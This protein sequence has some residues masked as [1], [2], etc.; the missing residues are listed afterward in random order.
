LGDQVSDPE[1]AL[2][3]LPFVVSDYFRATG[4][5]GDGE[6]R[7]PIVL[8]VGESHCG[9][10]P[11]GALGDCYHFTYTPRGS[12]AGFYWQYPAYNWGAEPGKA[13]G[14]G[15]RKV[16]FQARPIS[17]TTDVPF[18]FL[19]GGIDDATLP[20]RDSFKA[21]FLTA[22]MPGWNRYEIDLSGTTYERVIGAFAWTVTLQGDPA[23]LDPVV[24]ELDDIRWEP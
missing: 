9:P 19:A 18:N 3:A 14:P 7:G 17:G 5:I 1:P 22:L 8:G 24:F 2:A 13:I 15:A 11:A 10:R 20:N 21:E 12:W 16:T 4:G 6:K 23:T